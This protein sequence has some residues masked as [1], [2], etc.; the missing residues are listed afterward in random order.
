MIDHK[1]NSIYRLVLCCLV[2]LLLNAAHS[3]IAAP[4]HSFSPEQSKESLKAKIDATNSRQGLADT[5]KANILKYY[6]SALDNLTSIDTFKAQALDFKQTAKEAPDKTKKIQ[7]QLAV[8]ETKAEKLKPDELSGISDAEL[9]QRLISEKEKLTGINEEL[10]K[11]DNELTLQQARPQQ[12]RNETVAAQQE[13]EATQQK[14]ESSH[15]TSSTKLEAEAE[16]IYLRT[17]LDA[18]AQEL[19]KLEIEALSN[20]AQIELLKAQQALLSRKK[21]QLTPIIALIETRLTDK[22]QT[23]AQK[24]E[25]ELS[26]TEQAL[27]GKPA[28]IQTVT[29]DNIQ[30]S[31][32]LQ[33]VNEKN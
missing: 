30:Y 29:R 22:K 23:E 26:H 6:Q 16:Q 11:V 10:I 13:L 32:E 5:E 18:R 9:V 15:A 19:K 27:A 21:N 20:P 7:Q 28:I 1:S 4:S 3:A 25:D 33:N 31:R 12:I 8:T 24:T 17:Q 14:L 2:W